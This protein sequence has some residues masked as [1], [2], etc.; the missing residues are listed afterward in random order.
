MDGVIQL[1]VDWLP[2][3][4]DREA[5]DLPLKSFNGPVLLNNMFFPGDKNRSVLSQVLIDRGFKRKNILKND[6]SIP[7]GLSNVSYQQNIRKMVFEPDGKDDKDEKNVVSDDF[8]GEQMLG[9]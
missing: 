8:S 5:S 6:K 1:M 3:L 9:P 2:V 7:K 4:K